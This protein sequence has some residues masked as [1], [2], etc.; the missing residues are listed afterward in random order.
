MGQGAAPPP[1]LG[2]G[3]ERPT[4]GQKGRIPGAVPGSATALITLHAKLPKCD[5]VLKGNTPLHAC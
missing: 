3:W 2:R 4:Q 5:L 1:P